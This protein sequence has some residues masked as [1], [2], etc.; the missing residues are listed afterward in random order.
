MGNCARDA[1]RLE[2]VR[3]VDCLAQLDGVCW[4]AFERLILELDPFERRDIALQRDRDHGRT[5]MLHPGGASILGPDDVDGNRRRAVRPGRQVGEDP[6]EQAGNVRG[7]PARLRESKRIGSRQLVDH[8]QA[9][10]NRG[11]VGREHLAG[12]RGGK[13]ESACLLEFSKGVLPG[14]IMG[15]AV[16][17]GDGDKPPAGGKPRKRRAHVAQGCIADP[18]LDVDRCRER[19]VH[20]H[21]AR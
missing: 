3:L 15:R 4:G 12:N 1:E 16:R 2:R 9:R 10:G 7:H 21:E 19:R 18:A 14:R 13:D 6:V 5:A 17:A 20:Q 8:G 11:A